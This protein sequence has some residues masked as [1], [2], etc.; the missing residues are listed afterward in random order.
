M[1][2][3][4]PISL[5]NKFNNVKFHDDVHKYFVG[6]KQL[7]SV[8]TLIHKYQQEFNHQYWSEYKADEYHL[9]QKEIERAWDF[10][11]KKATLKGSIAHNYAENLWNNKFF[12]YP[13]ELVLKTFGY[14][15][16][17]EEFIKTKKLIDTFFRMSYGTLIPI[18]TE[19]VICDVEYGIGG[20]IDLLVYNTK[21]KEFQLWD[22]KTNKKLNTENKMGETL[23]GSL[24]TLQD[25]EMEIYSL[26][27]GLYKKI[28][29]KNTGIKIGR[30]YLVWISHNNDEPIYHEIMD[31]SKYVDIMVNEYVA[32]NQL[33]KT[34]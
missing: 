17:Y 2:E 4:L 19:Y 26:Q 15:P 21:Q 12:P 10:L 23:K 34:A 11:N 6:D 14:D 24:F 25:C 9:D 7:I 16:I 13:K 31:R 1:I 5:F 32:E 22:Y 30:C 33:I 8:T 18:K 27:L 28:I 20:M 3:S 29:E